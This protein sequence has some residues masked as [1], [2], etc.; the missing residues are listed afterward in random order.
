[1]DSFDCYRVAL[2]STD[3][4]LIV[5]P[6]QTSLH[7]VPNAKSSDRGVASIDGDNTWMFP[8]PLPDVAIG[9]PMNILLSF[10]PYEHPSMWHSTTPVVSV[11]T[12]VD[13][14]SVDRMATAGGAVWLIETAD[15]PVHEFDFTQQFPRHR[16]FANAQAA[17]IDTAANLYVHHYS[18]HDIKTLKVGHP[19]SIEAFSLAD[20]TPY[21]SAA[22]ATL[23]T[24]TNLFDETPSTPDPS[25]EGRER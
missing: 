21:V 16:R 13:G 23:A 25:H 17:V 9:K 10:A 15:G 4:V 18:L 1:M 24:I 2:H 6:M 3:E 20:E 8:K 12:T 22:A 11:T 19:I 5:Q 7:V 14:S